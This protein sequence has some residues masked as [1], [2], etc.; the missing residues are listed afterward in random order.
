MTNDGLYKI[1]VQ[2]LMRKIEC[3][4]NYEDDSIM[5]GEDHPNTKHWKEALEETEEA[6]KI[7]DDLKE[8]LLERCENDEC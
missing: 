7:F 8:K 6:I 2:L 1:S 4:C 3:K 5:L